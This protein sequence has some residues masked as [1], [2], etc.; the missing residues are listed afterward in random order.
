MTIEDTLVRRQVFVQRFAGGRASEAEKLV[1]RILAQAQARLLLEPTEYQEIRLTKLIKDLNIMIKTGYADLTQKTID[2]LT[3]YS[4]DEVL[5]YQ[6]VLQ[7]GSS[8][9]LAVPAIEQVNQAVMAT[10]M[11]ATIGASKITISEALTTFERKKS[12]EIM[13]AINDGIL[14]GDTTPEIA[15]N[16]GA[17][18]TRHKAQVNALTRTVI[19]HSSNQAHKAFN[20]ENQSILKGEEWVATLD[21]R[22]T[23]IC[24]G[25][26]GRIYPV[27]NGPYPPAHWNCRSLRIPVVK[28]EFAL[29]QQGA[30]RPEVGKDGSGQVSANTKFDGWLRRQPADFQDEYFSQFADGKEKAK[31]FRNGKLDIQSFRDETGK[32]YTLDQLRQLEPV[33]FRKANLTETV[34]P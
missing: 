33:A 19:N 14:H 16:I 30:K 27:G 7:N 17:L 15:K 26:D 18:T 21:N 32:N 8:V 5:F 31:L 12:A 34:F 1:A 2:V 22:T 25:R 24:G 4:A 20:V 28:D 23:L 13:R 29:D 6:S 11:D 10:G 9:Q 3:D